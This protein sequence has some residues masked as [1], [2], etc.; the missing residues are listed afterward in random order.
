[1]T[2]QEN[3]IRVNQTLKLE[4]DKLKEENDELQYTLS[5]LY[6]SSVNELK[7]ENFIYKCKLTI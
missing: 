5:Q 6:K 3:S 1:M 7:V 4:N 2:I